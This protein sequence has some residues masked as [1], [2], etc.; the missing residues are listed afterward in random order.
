MLGGRI[1][2]REKGRFEIT[3]V[4]PILKERDRLIGRA[5][6]GARP[7]CPRHLREDAHRGA[8]AGGAAGSRA[9]RC[10]TPLVD[11]V[12]ERFQPLLSQGAV[13]VD[14]ADER[15]QPRL[16]V[17]L[18][19]A[20]R[21]GRQSRHGEPRAISQRLQFIL[22]ARTARPRTA[23]PRPIS[24]A[25]R[26]R[27]EE[28]ALVADAIR[29]ALARRSDVEQRALGYAI[30]ELVPQHLEEVRS[31]RLA[32]ID[33]VE[34]EVRAR[35]TREINY[36]DAPR[37]AAARGG[38]RRQGAADQRPERRGH[39]PRGWS[40]GCTS[41]RPSSTASARS[42][43]CR[44]CSRARRWS[45]RAACC[46]P[47]RWKPTPRSRGFAD[48]PCTPRRDRAAGHGGRHGRRARA[49]PRA[50]RRRRPRRRA[51][52]SRAAT[53]TTGHLRFIE[54]K[55]RQARWP[56]RD[57]DQERDPGLAQRARALLLA[58]VRIDDGFARTRLR[59]PL[60]RS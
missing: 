1:P 2:A 53:A 17:Y 28:R 8:A 58:M 21:D 26:S 42:R 38:A 44:R 10:S 18:E 19:H 56:R 39:R 43:R 47:G 11:V 36:W 33:K 41:A 54:V 16:L 9:I 50:A 4:P 27:A 29:G 31:R 48:D 7:L 3:R 60:L 59:A 14:E 30:A 15:E 23:A 55:G 37:R 20:V 32:E 5:R 40:S 46:A 24:T 35:L 12:L 57:P 13:L 51:G 45:S 25:G 49:R 34:R 6:S 52:T 22:L